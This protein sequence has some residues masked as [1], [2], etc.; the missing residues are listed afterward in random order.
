[1]PLFG[2]FMFEKILI[3]FLCV[4]IQFPIQGQRSIPHRNNTAC[5]VNDSEATVTF[6]QIKSKNKRHYYGAKWSFVFLH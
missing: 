3:R 4:T 2:Q 6:V 1:M 5:A